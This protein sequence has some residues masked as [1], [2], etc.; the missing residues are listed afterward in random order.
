MSS[1]EETEL[2]PKRVAVSLTEREHASLQD[3]AA[4]QR[5]PV[6]KVVL[7]IIRNHLATGKPAPAPSEADDRPDLPPAAPRKAPLWLPPLVKA[8]YAS[9]ARDRASGVQSLL[10]RYPSELDDLPADWH[11]AAAVREQ[12][13]ALSCWRD[14]LDVG[15]YDDPRM[16]LAFAASLM[17][18]SQ[19]LRER[20]RPGAQRRG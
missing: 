1:S 18:F 5:A 6:A 20:R 8:E 7:G 4:Q 12:L 3:I 13:W 9:W 16:E 10:D 11:L 15:L 17:D 19:Y 14:F 2:R